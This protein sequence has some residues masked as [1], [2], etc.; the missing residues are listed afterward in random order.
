MSES[1]LRVCY[2]GAYRQNY[3]RNRIM[4]AGLRRNGVIVTECHETLWQGIE[5]R[6]NAV[7]GG[8]AKAGFLGAS[9][10]HL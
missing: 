3:S 8:L 5:D 1:A 4:I 7:N 6:V 9:D 2:F 10:S